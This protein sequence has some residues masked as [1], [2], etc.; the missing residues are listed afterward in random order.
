[1]D[2]LKKINKSVMALVL[3]TGLAFSIAPNVMAQQPNVDFLD[4]SHYNSEQG[5][6]LSFYQTAKAGNV[7]GVVVK[8]SEG[9]YYVDPAAS[10]NIANA[11]QAGMVVSAYHFARYKSVDGAK[12]EADWFDK[13]LQLVGFNKTGDGY[14]VVDIEDN[15]LT[16]DKTALTAYTNAFITEMKRLGYS[17]VDVYSGSYYYNNRLQPSNLPS[18]P[19]LA[20]YPSNPVAGQPTANFSNGTGAWQ[21]TSSWTGMAG[22]GRFDASEDYAGKY[23]NAVK[24]STP[25]VGTIGNI[26]LVDYL[27]SKGMDAFFTA[28]TNLATQYGIT[29]YTGSAAQNLALLSKLQNGIQPAK[30]NIDNSK[31]N[32]DQ[33]APRPITSPAVSNNAKQ[34]TV[35]VKPSTYKVQSGDSLSKITAKYGMTVSNLAVMNGIKN[36][37]FIRVGQV[38]KLTGTVTQTVASKVAYYTVRKG[39]T[40]WELSRKFGTSMIQI[41]SWNK[42][43]NNYVIN[44]GQKL[45][46]R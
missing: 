16:T 19:W 22:Y 6:P 12:N 5:L 15:S 40:V 39:D 14:V 10:V 23:T 32:T 7:Q 18:K 17:K 35:V 20:S 46:M 2:I 43:N 37:N 30:I 24:D 13:K 38:L 31:L 1:M 25:N 9:T 34:P 29:D 28:R 36:K 4:V 42:L 26:S 11:R 41:K 3:S 44:P 27:K 33:P 8:V 21:W 45:R